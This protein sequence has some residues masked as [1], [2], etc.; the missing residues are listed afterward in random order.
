MSENSGSNG[1]TTLSNGAT[2]LQ[3]ATD[4]AI[5]DY[6]LK[7]VINLSK[8]TSGQI[9]AWNIG[10]EDAASLTFLDGAGRTIQT[11]SLN[12]IQPDGHQSVSAPANAVNVRLNDPTATVNLYAARQSGR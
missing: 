9:V 12:S 3:P 6:Y 4:Q 1:Q 10:N 5:E 7:P 2:V 11:T 8:S